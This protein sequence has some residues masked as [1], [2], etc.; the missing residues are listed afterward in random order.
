M[1]IDLAL[2]RGLNNM[3]C[4]QSHYKLLLCVF[5]LHMEMVVLCN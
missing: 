5:W 4:S 1:K 3:E 2:L